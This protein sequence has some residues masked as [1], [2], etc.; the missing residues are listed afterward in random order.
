MRS[1]ECAVIFAPGASDEALGQSVQ[2]YAQ[3]IDTGGG[4]ITGVET[5][6][7]RKLAY[8]IQHNSEGFYY[9]FKFRTDGNL[10]GELGRQ[11]RIDE[12]VIRHMIIRDELASG[13]ETVVAAD[14][15]EAVKTGEPQEVYGGETRKE[16][17][18]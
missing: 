16:K 17:E 5:W 10:L 14:K 11:L 2:K 3:V 1:Y 18:R 12:S 13:K 7:K 4:Q 8:E 6:G 15:V 9:F